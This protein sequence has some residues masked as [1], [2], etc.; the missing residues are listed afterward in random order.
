MDVF[1]NAGD[2]I[3]YGAN[4][5]EVV[6]LLCEKNVLSILGNYDLEVIEG[7]TKTKGEKKAAFKFAR[8]ELKKTCECYLY[9]FATGTQAGGCR[10]KT[11][12]N[13]WKPRID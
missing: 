11:V 12:C 2:S 1:L 10:Q 13:S 8:K 3:G 7:K 5:N 4:P 9:F 6:E